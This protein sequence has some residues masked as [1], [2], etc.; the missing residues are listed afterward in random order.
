MKGF[1]VKKPKSSFISG[2]NSI[3]KLMTLI[4]ALAVILLLA[5]CSSS[6]GPAGQAIKAAEAAYDAI[7]VEAFKCIPD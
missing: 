1:K 2:G 7:K 4:L 6:K 3:K 5:A